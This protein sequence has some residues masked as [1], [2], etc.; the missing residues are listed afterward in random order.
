MP[1][2]ETTMP[3]KIKG[4]KCRE[5]GTQYPAEASHVCEFCFGPLEVDYD[6][7]A[8]GKRLTRASIQAGPH[9]LWRYLDL[10]PVEGGPSCG[11]TRTCC[12]SRARPPAATGWA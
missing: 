7:E 10:L 8:I 2:K 1:G 4:L 6:Y 9:S 12:P 3:S 11:A 5:C